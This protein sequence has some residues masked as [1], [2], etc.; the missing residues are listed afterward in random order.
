MAHVVEELCNFHCQHI[1]LCARIEGVDD[2]RWYAF[3]NRYDIGRPYNLRVCLEL[4]K[5]V[6]TNR[7]VYYADVYSGNFGNLQR[8]LD[9]LSEFSE[10]KWLCKSVRGGAADVALKSM[11][12]YGSIVFEESCMSKSSSVGFGDFGIPY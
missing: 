12:E 3:V 4:R 9:R 8:V 2:M 10:S 7:G 1:V 5:D 11:M 6:F